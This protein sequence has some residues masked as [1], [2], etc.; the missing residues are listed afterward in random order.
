MNKI[1]NV[2]CDESCHL[3]HDGIND[4]VLGAV[5]CDQ[6][7]IKQ[8]NRDIRDM[9][10]RYGVATKAELKWTKVAPVKK[11]L[12]EELVNYFF[13]NPALHYRCI[14][15][16]DKNDQDHIRFHQTHDDW[17][18]KMYFDLLQ[19]ILS[20]SDAYE[21]Y[22]DIKDTHSNQKIKKL[23]EVSRNSIYDFSG[24]VIKRIQP[25]RSDEVQLMQLVDVL[26]GAV[27]YQNRIFP[28]NHRKS[29][30]KLEII[31]LL[32]KRSGYRLTRSTLL[33]EEKFNIFVWQARQYK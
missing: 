18:Y 3:Q 10:E 22:I 30:T 13:D 5:W 19:G 2:Y 1:Y 9:K 23:E 14:V 20:P 16:T 4:M 21:I 7:K 11:D 28:D 17:Y 32:K 12:Y 8:V 26:V 6:T 31:E 24:E 33:K 15:I 27:T 29:E 25:I